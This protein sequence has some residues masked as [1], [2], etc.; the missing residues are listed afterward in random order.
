MT[1]AFTFLARL[2]QIAATIGKYLGT[3][4]IRWLLRRPYDGPELLRQ[5]FENLSGS[6]IKFGQILSL[7]VDSLPRAYCNALLGLLD[8]VPPVARED[9]D[10]VFLS[11][12]G[13]TPA[14]TYG[15]FDYAP[16]AS[17]SIGQVHKAKL[18][19]GTPV[20]VKVQRPH[21]R[22]V[23]ERDNLVLEAMVRFILFF[24]IRRAYF[25]R[26]AVRELTTWTLDE[27]DYRREAA[28]CQL[29]GENAKKTPTERVPKV[30][31]ELSRGRV[32]T[33]EFLEGPSVAQYL[34]M[35]QANN[36]EGLAKLRERGFDASRFSSNVISNFLNDAFRYGV[37]H[38]DLHP[39]NLLILPGNV[40]GYVDFGIV[41]VLTQEARRKQIELTM[42]YASGDAEAIYQGFLNICIVSPDAD[43]KGMRRKIQQLCIK[44]YHE[45]A[46]G[47]LA[48]FRV[49]VT[50]AMSDLLGI[51]QHYGVL[52]DRE[53]IKYIRSTVFADGLVSLIA[54]GVDLAAILRKLVEEYLQE[55]AQQ[56]VFSTRAAMD[57][58]TSMVLWLEKGPQGVMDV[59]NRVAS[60][61]LR[62]KAAP[63]PVPATQDVIRSRAISTAAV[64]A[65]SVS[66]VGFGLVPLQDVSRVAIVAGAGFLAILS[67]RLYLLLRRMAT[68]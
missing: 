56:Q 20:A 62:I 32:L 37:F 31:L 22:K 18:Q 57:L 26:D 63:P 54:P 19:D 36:E 58:L 49:S 5:L 21:I 24:R 39:A 29:L 33:M 16:L 66:A 35:I 68:E 48:R 30:Y 51:C 60:G 13:K 23:F 17:A 9:V 2:F 61:E 64:W 10:A 25:M 15:E 46:P 45:A 42:A 6:F 44:W 7:Q 12:I 50:E 55:E 53:M 67:V 65:A 38:A 8:R 43:L 34:R 28:Y 3:L 11:E 27:L 14:E 40:V 41:A 59:V 52:V 4:A 47:S 1:P